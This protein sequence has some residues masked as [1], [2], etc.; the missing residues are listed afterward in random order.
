MRGAAAFGLHDRLSEIRRRYPRFT[1]TFDR[2][3]Q[4]WRADS[5]GHVIVEYTLDDLEMTLDRNDPR[6]GIDQ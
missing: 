6:K 2:A 4:V 5:K 3:Q 1:I